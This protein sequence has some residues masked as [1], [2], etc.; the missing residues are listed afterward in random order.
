MINHIC[1]KVENL[2]VSPKILVICLTANIQTAK[3]QIPDYTASINTFQA[4]LA[5]GLAN[6]KIRMILLF[7]ILF[8]NYEVLWGKKVVS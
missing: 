3:M 2:S 8:E 7:V 5:N 4:L 6:Y 1:V